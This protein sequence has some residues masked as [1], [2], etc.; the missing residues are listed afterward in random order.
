MPGLKSLLWGGAAKSRAFPIEGREQILTSHEHACVG[1][2]GQDLGKEGQDYVG[3]TGK[4][5]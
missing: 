3:T 4:K 1:K 5:N 2:E